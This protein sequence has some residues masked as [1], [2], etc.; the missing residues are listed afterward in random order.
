MRNLSTICSS[1][2]HHTI[3]PR[4]INQ[5]VIQDDRHHYVI[6]QVALFAKGDEFL[7]KERSTCFGVKLLPFFGHVGSKFSRCDALCFGYL[8]CHTFSGNDL[9]ILN[10]FILD[11]LREDG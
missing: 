11:S 4:L 10:S 6:T 7:T 2:I 8:E 5:S 1:I 3:H 9:S